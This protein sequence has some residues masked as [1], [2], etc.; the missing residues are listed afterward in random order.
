[1]GH[2]LLSVVVPAFNEEAILAD[3]LT[4]IRDATSANRELAGSWELIVCDNNST[5]RT[6]DIAKE[7]GAKVVHESE[8]Q[9]SRARNSGAAAAKGEWLLFVDA[10]THPS[11]ALIDD[12]FE[13]A[14][15]GNYI[16]CGTTIRIEGGSK[17][18]K[19]RLER[20]NPLYRLIQ[21]SGGAFLLINAKA[22]RAV[23]G[24]SD[25]LFVLEEVDFLSRLKRYGR[26]H[27]KRFIVLT[28]HPVV[29]SG[30]KDEL[31]LGSLFVLLV[32]NFIAIFY[33]FLY[34]LLPRRFLP[35]IS[36][37]L[38]RYWYPKNRSETGPS[39]T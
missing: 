18:N 34:L 24:F 7:Y 20:L 31:T 26:K 33:F 4:K 11:A 9:I 32:S 15:M 23:E 37:N 30:R 16:G 12:A 1:M 39:K 6:A 13:H 14:K 22:F 5:D 38:L 21:M 35:Q 25:D 8:N 36:R 10:D 28:E 3:T 17:F 29:S 2:V 27:G 19:L